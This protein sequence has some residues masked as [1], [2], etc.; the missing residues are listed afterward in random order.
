MNRTADSPAIKPVTPQENAAAAKRYRDIIAML[1]EKKKVKQQEAEAKREPIVLT[2]A[3][4]E[5]A[6]WVAL[7]YDKLEAQ[8][9]KESANELRNLTPEEFQK[10][11]EETTQK[12]TRD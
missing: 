4:R 2:D 7:N 9:Q 1:A 5:N 11:V 6:L 8:H 12:N 3:E 10:R